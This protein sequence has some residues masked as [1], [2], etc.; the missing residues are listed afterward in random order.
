LQIRHITHQFKPHSVSYCSAKGA[1]ARKDK[2]FVNLLNIPLTGMM[3]AFITTIALNRGRGIFCI[4][5][6]FAKRIKGRE[7][8]NERNFCF[9][10]FIVSAV[11]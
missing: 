3:F 1:Q 10:R 6:L 9:N 7:L 2:P 4:Y 5:F 11:F 8:W